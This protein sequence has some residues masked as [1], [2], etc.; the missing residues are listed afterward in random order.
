MIGTQKKRRID[1]HH[2]R[3]YE[4]FLFIPRALLIGIVVNCALKEQAVARH[5]VDI[6]HASSNQ[7]V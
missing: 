3:S 6:V 7:T 2:R 4:F 1:N 5:N